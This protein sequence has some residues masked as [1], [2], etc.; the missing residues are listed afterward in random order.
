MNDD[1]VC[2]LYE[3]LSTY[4]D[5]TKSQA[6]K[7]Y[8]GYSQWISIS[9]TRSFETMRDNLTLFKNLEKLKLE[10]NL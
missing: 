10:R 3:P 5:I 7:T 1:D 9:Q 6:Q 4:V 8:G 2:L